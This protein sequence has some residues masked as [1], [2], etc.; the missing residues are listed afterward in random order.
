MIYVYG[1]RCFLFNPRNMQLEEIASLPSLATTVFANK[2]DVFTLVVNEDDNIG[3]VMKY[4][5]ELNEWR[6]LATLPI[7]LTFI[8]DGIF[9]NDVLYILGSTETDDYCRKFHHL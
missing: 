7:P 4:N 6:L 8:G 1:I 3:S 2:F 5:F 9:Y